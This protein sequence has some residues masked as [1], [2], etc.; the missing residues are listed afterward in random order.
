M[1]PFNLFGLALGAAMA[2]RLLLTV[3]TLDRRVSE[4]EFKMDNA[5]D[6]LSR[7]ESELD[8]RT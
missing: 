2:I 4:L 8:S 3:H 1:D 6:E 5:E 7:L